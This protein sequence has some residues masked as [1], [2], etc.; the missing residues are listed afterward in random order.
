VTRKAV[1]TVAVVLSFLAQPAQASHDP[2]DFT[3]WVEAEMHLSSTPIWVPTHRVYA[4][5]TGFRIGVN[6]SDRKPVPFR[7][8]LTK[9]GSTFKCWT[10]SAWPLKR[11]TVTE[12]IPE[13]RYVVKWWVRSHVV[14]TW[15]LHIYGENA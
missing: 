4:H 12:F 1:L 6:F 2:H 10:G 14:A 13:G 8:C 9:K 15:P 11:I 7:V 3:G 5:A